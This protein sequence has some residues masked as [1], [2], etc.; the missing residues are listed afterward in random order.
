GEGRRLVGPAAAIEEVEAASGHERII[1]AFAEE[2]RAPHRIARRAGKE[3]V[4]ALA[5]AQLVSAA[6]TEKGVIAAAAQDAV[7]AGT[8]EQDAGAGAAEEGIIPLAAIDVTDRVGR[9][10]HGQA[11]AAGAGKDRVVAPLAEKNVVA[12][13]VGAGGAG[14]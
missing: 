9:T 14:L 11:R 1:A 2:L 7:V 8:A 5:A 10:V 13:A 4:T 3:G 12:V 6:D